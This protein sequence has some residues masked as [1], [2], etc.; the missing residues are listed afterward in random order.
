MS[1]PTLT[2][3]PQRNDD[4]QQTLEIDVWD[5]L[6]KETRKLQITLTCPP[7]IDQSAKRLM[8]AL[9]GQARYHTHVDSLLSRDQRVYDGAPKDSGIPAPAEA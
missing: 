3:P 2:N 9:V 5:R 6:T 4:M 7:A 1:R 8:K